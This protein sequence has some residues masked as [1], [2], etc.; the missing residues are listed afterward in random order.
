MTLI[1][2]KHRA[3]FLGYEIDK[4]ERRKYRFRRIGGT[5]WKDIDDL[6]VLLH[7][8]GDKSCPA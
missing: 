8:L 3:A 1:N 2:A 5:Q 7:M 6:Y 4:G